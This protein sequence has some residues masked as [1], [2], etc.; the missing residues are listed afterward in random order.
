ML[1]V[2]RISTFLVVSVPAKWVHPGLVGP[3]QHCG[4]LG[5]QGSVSPCARQDKEL[6]L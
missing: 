5:P 3:G 1:F 2:D 6:M 4:L